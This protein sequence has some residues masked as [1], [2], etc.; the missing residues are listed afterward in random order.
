[1]TLLLG[2]VLEPHPAGGGEGDLAGS[3]RRARSLR[4]RD[5]AG[6]VLGDVDRDGLRRLLVGRRRGRGRE[7]VREGRGE[8]RR[9]GH[10]N[11]LGDADLDVEGLADG[12]RGLL[13]DGLRR[14][15]ARTGRL[16]DSGDASRV[17]DASGQR[18]GGGRAVRVT[19][20]GDVASVLGANG[21]GL[22]GEVII[23]GDNLALVVAPVVIRLLLELL[24]AGQLL[25]VVCAKRR[26][27]CRWRRKR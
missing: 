20:D 21:R 22:R 26:G 15:E 6:R 13:S 23:V 27:A 5:V 10:V 18:L 16:R 17:R 7:A 9:R 12:D 24:P 4:V 14:C 25:R 3:L 1:M 2:V 19:I 11:D 8:G